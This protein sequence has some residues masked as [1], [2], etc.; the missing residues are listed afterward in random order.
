MEFRANGSTGPNMEIR[1]PISSPSQEPEV[2]NAFTTKVK[3]WFSVPCQ[4]IRT[5]IPQPFGERRWSSSWM[6]HSGAS[7]PRRL[8][9]AMTG[10]QHDNPTKIMKEIARPHVRHPRQAIRKP[11]TQPI[12]SVDGV[13]VRESADRQKRKNIIS[14]EARRRTVKFIVQRDGNESR[15]HQPDMT[16]ASRPNAA[17]NDS[18][19]DDR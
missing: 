6:W 5:H 3:P 19:K 10:R 18:W 14:H 4:S 15:L 1:R 17:V 11:P 2:I 16:P 9:H 13:G 7:H 12:L 8:Q